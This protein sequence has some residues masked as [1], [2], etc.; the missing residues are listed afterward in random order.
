M[1]LTKADLDKVRDVEGFPIAKD[2]DIIEL[3][4]P[5]YYT[6]CPN[7]FIEDFIK[8]NGSVYDEANDDYHREPFAADVS[9]GKNDPLYNA[10]SYHTKVPYRAIMHYILH[11]T[12]PGDIVFDGFCGTGMTG[13][14]A[15]MCGSPDQ[16]T[17][18]HIE[19]QMVGEKVKWGNRRAILNDLS[20]AATFIASNYNSPVSVTVFAETA[21]KI[22][23]K[24]EAEL[25]WMYDT[26][27][28]DQSGQQVLGFSGKGITGKIN[29]IVWSDVFVCPSCSKEI[30]YWEPETNDMMAA[31]KD[32]MKCTH[33]GC[34][35]DRNK[36]EHAM[37][38]RYDAETGE[39]ISEAK[40]VP[41]R[42]NYS[43]D[44]KRFQKRPD[45]HDLEVIS[46]IENMDI[47]GWVPKAVLK[48][49]YNTEQPKNSHGFKHIHQFYYRR[50]LIFLAKIYAE[51]AK[52]NRLMFWF[53]SALPKLT[54][55]NRY[56][57]QHGSRALVG[58][59]AG[60]YYIAPLRVEN[61]VISQYEFQLKKIIQVE[62][63]TN[64]YISTGSLTDVSMI[65]NN[66]IDYIFTD[67]P[68]GGNLNYSE[69]S[70]LWENW[71][72]VETND[73][74]ETIMNVVQQKG[75]DE[76]QALMV[77]CIEE[78][79]RVLKP[80]RWITIEFHNSQNS[81]WNSIQYAIGNAG[82][83]IAD[84]RVLD[85]QR[86]TIKQLSTFSAVKQDLIISAY[87]PTATFVNE[88][89]SHAGDPEMAWKF[90]REHLSH[91][92]VTADAN[93]D[94]KLDIISERQNY[95][96]FD[97]MVAWHIMRGIP[98][99]MDSHTFYEG[100]D[101]RFLKRDDM[102]FLPD[103]VN[104]YDEKRAQMPIEEQQLSFVVTDEKNAIGWLNYV[105]GSGAKTYQELQPLYLQEL[106][107]AKQEKMPELLDMLREN[108]LQDEKGAWYV[109]DIHSAVDLAKI[110]RKALLK[111]FN[112]SCVPGKA[113]LKVF[114][115]EAIR[116][117]FDE[118]WKNRDYKT[119]V[120][121][122]QKL[123]ET[124]LQEDP[125]LL[126]YYDNASSRLQ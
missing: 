57:P 82:F 20:P 90:V 11:Y 81:V 24:C 55:M 126:M 54:K 124:A 88:F 40:A 74:A 21:Q 28:V 93:R 122:G 4:K 52:D 56:M 59:M 94:G 103:Q 33:C 102:Y 39:T 96:L 30:I 49:G 50:Q 95:L 86:G 16:E 48:Y 66:S 106:H 112:D 27:H 73:K 61:E 89:D 2:D 91:V 13:V 25:G 104:E 87:K 1:K 10:H 44:K 99:P 42:I 9:E 120:A 22:I 72:K 125:A 35:A 75:I 8:E 63:P 46:K 37:I 115:M 7:P 6:A 41:V 31:P 17:K 76:Y 62:L 119:I 12:N 34:I 38:T 105:L 114:R 60:T 69:L 68:F 98:V 36:C 47:P 32:K 121:V 80:G 65:P 108:F 67:P 15:Q 110:R 71:L 53:T 116:A 45:A 79:Y 14:A 109:P 18:L 85:K 117:G 100:L 3:S 19:S 101:E 97:R 70:A 23:Q 84:V 123:P 5:P 113:K 118:C 107:Q 83:I 29:Y 51:C 64:S 111:E 58:P 92:A 77:K 78:Y 26:N 43:I